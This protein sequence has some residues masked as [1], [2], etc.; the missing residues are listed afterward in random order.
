[1]I[2]AFASTIIILVAYNTWMTYNW[3][4]SRT[5]ATKLEEQH[6][7]ATK[8]LE[9]EKDLRG[10]QVRIYESRLRIKDSEI[11]AF[12]KYIIEK[13]G[14]PFMVDVILGM[15]E[16]AADSDATDELTGYE[17]TKENV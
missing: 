14:N 7:T 16:S 5:K 17:P 9:A 4:Q 1:M 10:R 12:K 6:S 11:E 3:I 2:I 13:S 8:F 15:S